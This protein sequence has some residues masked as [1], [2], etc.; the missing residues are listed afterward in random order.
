M[1]KKSEVIDENAGFASP[2]ECNTT[3]EP[4]GRS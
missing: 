1:W 2:D 4:T 3:T